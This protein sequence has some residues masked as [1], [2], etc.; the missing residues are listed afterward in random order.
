VGSWTRD[1][2]TPLFNNDD[3]SYNEGPFSM[4]TGPCKRYVEPGGNTTL[5][6]QE[7]SMGW[8]FKYTPSGSVTVS[9]DGTVSKPPTV[10]FMWI[11]R[12]A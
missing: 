2:S 1:A 7:R 3:G 6:Y 4:F 5:P 11:L 12:Y 8:E 10:A 9:S